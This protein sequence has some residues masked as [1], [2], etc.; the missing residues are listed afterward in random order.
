MFIV[1]LYAWADHINTKLIQ[2][3]ITVL[4]TK[5]R[6]HK[7]EKHAGTAIQKI[8]EGLYTHCKV[9]VFAGEECEDF[10]V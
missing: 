10:T 2:N 7:K 4:A 8:S 5:V 1:S 9:L 3:E 6:V